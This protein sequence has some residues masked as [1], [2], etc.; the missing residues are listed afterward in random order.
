M[1]LPIAP[2]PT[3]PD[4]SAETRLVLTFLES[5]GKRQDAEFY[6]KLFREVPKA[7]FALVAIDS[8]ILSDAMGLLVDSLQFL[9]KL[10]LF[11]V[12]VRGLDEVDPPT[13]AEVEEGEQTLREFVRELEHRDLSLIVYPSTEPDLTRKIVRDIELEHTVCVDF[14]NDGSRSGFEALGELAVALNS[15]K[16]VLLRTRGGLG[17][18]GPSQV[19]LSPSHVLP[20]DDNGIG[21]I[22][23]RTDYEPLL[24]S[25]ALDEDER[26]LLSQTS[27]VH[28]RAPNLITSI[29]SPLDLLR[30]L[31]TVRGAGTLLKTGSSILRTET[32]AA[33]DSARLLT[34]VETA[35]DRRVKPEFFQRRTLNVY[36]EEDYRGAAIVQPGIDPG[37]AYLTKFA[38]VKT[39]QGEGLGRELWEAVVRDY[40]VLYWR[41]RA[42]N[43]IAAWYASQ[44]DGMHRVGNWWIYWRGVPFE[45]VPELCNDALQRPY[46]LV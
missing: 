27:V 16:L 40:P 29:T 4:A 33:L 31:F 2:S 9:S 24:Q 42:Q 22:N 1:N 38:V 44:C 14:S 5:V 13:P 3:P 43:P 8:E 18:K 23:L 37:S 45:R 34:L 32:Y 7:S 36:Y 35:F 39:A 26:W 21:V 28:R 19:N 46:D 10:D 41:A 17:P 11:P 25:G 15:R 20:T 30:E 12:L 6:L